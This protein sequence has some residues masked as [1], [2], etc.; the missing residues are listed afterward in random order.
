MAWPQLKGLSRRKPDSLPGSS[1]EGASRAPQRT[2]C[3]RPNP[4]EM[5]G[6]VGGVQDWTLPVG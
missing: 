4:V 2:L 3:C 6:E 5:L 1:L